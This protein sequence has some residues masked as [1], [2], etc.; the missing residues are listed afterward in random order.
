MSSSDAATKD[1]KKMTGRIF[2]GAGMSRDSLMAVEDL[3]GRVSMD[4]WSKEVEQEV[5]QRVQEKAAAKAKQIVSAANAE[6]RQIREQAFQEGYEQGIAEAQEQLQQA[7]KE[8]ADS[9]GQA[10]AEVR[11]GRDAIWRTQRANLAALV[12]VAVERICNIELDRNRRD[13][14]AGFLDQAVEA[15]DNLAGL[16]ITVHPDDEETMRDL[17]NFA[18][19]KHPQL[20]AWRIKADPAMQP[21]G[22][23]VEGEHGMVDNTLEGRRAIVQPILDQLELP[24]GD[25]ATK[26][27]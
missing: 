19:Q 6:A 21:G 7:H 2:V 16:N 14:L 9:L 25:T 11:K 27:G 20:Q 26:K 24:D 13:I 5:M 10:L 4:R 1:V 15:L 22:L 18:G 8:M 23:L 3:Q 17:L 12:H